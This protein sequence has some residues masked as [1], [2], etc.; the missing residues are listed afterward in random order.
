MV[1][2]QKV[3]WDSLHFYDHDF[4]R[5]TVKSQHDCSEHLSGAGNAIDPLC[6]YYLFLSVCVWPL[7]MH[8]E[9]KHQKLT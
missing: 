9:A 1:C 6:T 2:S 3:S 7:Y 4:E 8:M 5:S